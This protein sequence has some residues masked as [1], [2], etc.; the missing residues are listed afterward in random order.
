[1]RSRLLARL[2]AKIDAA[3][4]G[5]EQDRLIAEHAGYLARV[6]EL[7]AARDEI[8]MLRKRNPK[9]ADGRL[10]ALLN[11]AEGLCHYYQDMGTESADR[12]RRAQ[13]ISRVGGHPD[14]AARAASWL[15]LLH[16]G[17]YGFE[18]MIECIEESIDPASGYDTGTWARSSMSMALTIHLANRFD[19]A[20]PWYRRA[21]LLAV[22]TEDEATIS[23]LIH[24][25][26]ALW[27][28]NVR[29]SRLGGPATSDTS[30]QALLGVL[31]TFNFDDLVGLSALK[32]FTP[33]LEAQIHSLESNYERALALYE[34]G[35]SELKVKAV[36]GWQ[37]WLQ[38]DRAWCS[39]QLGQTES[40]QSALAAVQAMIAGNHHVDDRAATLSRLAQCWRALGEQKAANVCE[41]EGRLC[42]SDF[43]CLQARMLSVATESEGFGAMQARHPL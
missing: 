29:N 9:L 31:S 19:L 36:V 40:A 6:G 7:D 28:A 38:A 32:A 13:A 10:S 3:S 23:A 22:E 21:H 41:A 33:L 18:E 43:E 14:L 17:S 20:L 39:I 2:K 26:A 8:L 5:I 1:M 34:S 15:G 16:Y 27:V 11:L 25:M 42:W 30:R 35:L 24:N 37:A 12:F 4:L